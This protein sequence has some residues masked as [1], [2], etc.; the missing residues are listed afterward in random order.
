MEIE[1]SRFN[2]DNI[3]T[4]LRQK[5]TISGK[6]NYWHEIIVKYIDEP[7]AKIQNEGKSV[8]EVDRYKLISKLFTNACWMPFFP[9]PKTIYVEHFEGVINEPEFTFW[10]LKYNAK[11]NCKVLIDSLHEPLDSPVAIIYIQEELKKIKKNEKEAK[12]LLKDGKVNIYD[13]NF[14]SEYHESIELLR[15]KADYYIK[16]QLSNALSTSNETIELYAK[17]VYF[18]HFLKTKLKEFKTTNKNKSINKESVITETKYP[19]KQTLKHPPQSKVPDVLSPAKESYH[20]LNAN[21][22]DNIRKNLSITN[23]HF[24]ESNISNSIVSNELTHDYLLS[25]FVIDNN[26]INYYCLPSARLLSDTEFDNMVSSGLIGKKE[27]VLYPYSNTI[28]GA[29]YS[30]SDLVFKLSGIMLNKP[31]KIKGNTIKYFTDLLP[32]FK[33]YANGFQDGFNGFDNIHIKPFFTLLAEKQDYINKVFEYITKNLFFKHSWAFGVNGFATNQ[34]NEIVSAFKD[35]QKQ[36]YFY[37][38]WT[39]VLSNNDLFAP[40][41]AERMNQDEK[42][43]Y[44]SKPKLSKSQRMSTVEEQFSYHNSEN[45]ISMTKASGNKYQLKLNN[46][47]ITKNEVLVSGFCIYFLWSKRQAENVRQ[48]GGVAERWVDNKPKFYYEYYKPILTKN[49]NETDPDKEFPLTNFLNEQIEYEKES[50]SKLIILPKYKP[51]FAIE[52]IIKW[53]NEYIDWLIKLLNE[54][55]D[56]NNNRMGLSSNLTKPQIEKL[57]IRL[58]PKYIDNSTLLVNFEEI[59]SG[60]Q[61]SRMFNE[62]K[63]IDIN[64]KKNPNQTSLRAFL[65]A[66]MKIKSKNPNQ[67][68]IDNCFTD[69]NNNRIVLAKYSKNKSTEHW[70]EKFEKIIYDIIKSN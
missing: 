15:I 68:L 23:W 60:K 59:F 28:F 61:L 40:L 17:Y 43:K 70:R 51:D 56:S 66:S 39:V 41:F 54:A 48:L 65:K 55:D 36:G 47:T 25:N 4:E 18:K 44:D 1:D 53:T 34:N 8:N 62:I 32:Y 64:P 52:D 33:E 49:E 22:I 30:R 3:Q 6:L 13:Y 10:F 69:I 67:K 46:D 31:L 26:I 21:F 5:K 58:K 37:K 7:I 42:K 2:I 38:A 57:F 20:L 11:I 9:I 29:Y 24:E 16:H 19:A 12:G 35:G 27:S 50:L 14:N 45:N 63:W